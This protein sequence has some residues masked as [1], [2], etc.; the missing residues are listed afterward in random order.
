MCGVNAILAAHLASHLGL[1][2][3]GQANELGL[4]R[5]HLAGMQARGEIVRAH[6]GVYRHVAVE[7]TLEQRVRAAL[8]AIGDGAVLSHRAAL[9]RHGVRNFECHLVEVTH[10]SRSLPLRDGVVAHRSGTLTPADVCRLDGV[11]TTTPART[12]I[13]TAFVMTPAL[14]ARYAQEWFADR[15][16]RQGE[17][18]ASMERA[19]NHPGVRRLEANLGGVVVEADSAA[20]ARLGKLLARAGLEPEHHVVVTTSGGYVFELDWAYPALRIGL[21]LDG[22]GIH[23]RSAGAFEDDRFRR[24]ELEIDDWRILNF[25]DRQSQRPGYVVDQVRRAIAGRVG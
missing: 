10:R 2:S 16:L 7:V 18:E 20:E 5:H 23:L 12:L 11:W 22:Y 6:V 19:G 3:V 4:T 17:L 15:K 25:T 24:N 13:D 8:L 1:I 9:A 14:A 21:E